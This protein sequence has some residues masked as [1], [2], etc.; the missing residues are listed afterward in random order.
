[1]AIGTIPSSTTKPDQMD[2]T[3]DTRTDK[4]VMKDKIVEKSIPKSYQQ[5]DNR[6]K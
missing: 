4:Q 6:K 3:N 1:M 5:T 2:H